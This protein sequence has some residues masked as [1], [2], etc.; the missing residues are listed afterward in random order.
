[1]NRQ[2]DRFRVKLPPGKAASLVM[3]VTGE[4]AMDLA[5]TASGRPV[6]T[7]PLSGTYG[8]WEPVMALPAELGGGEI[9]VTVTALPRE[10][11]ASGGARFGSFH[12]WVYAAP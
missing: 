1:M 2:R 9:E 7:V 5:V 4:A 10:G 3:R 6:A 12:Y 11:E 8:W